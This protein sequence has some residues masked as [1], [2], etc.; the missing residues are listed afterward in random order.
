MQYEDD[1]IIEQRPW[2]FF[3][4]VVSALTVLLTTGTQPAEQGNAGAKPIVGPVIALAAAAPRNVDVRP[5]NL[6]APSETAV[7]LT[8]EPD[9]S[10]ALFEAT[11]ARQDV[12]GREPGVI[13]FETKSIVT[14]EKAVAAVFVL[15]RS[16]SQNGPTRVRWASR[17]GTAD[18]AIDFSD[19]SG[20]ALM[21]DH[22][23]QAALYVPLR[24]D[25]LKEG[26]ETFEVC[27][28][29][30]AHARLDR[31]RCAEGT[32]RDDD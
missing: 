32:I 3:A 29:S 23:R 5:K 15:K 27:L 21:A 10:I 9:E 4:F 12:P 31:L 18:A 8:M 6:G 14:T 11:S 22:Q 19:A 2:G 1:P 25:L 24:N 16:Q 13:S 26:D 17:S 20:T 30:A 28:H 7:P